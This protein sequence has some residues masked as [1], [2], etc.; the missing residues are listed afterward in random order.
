MGSFALIV[1]LLL[2]AAQAVF[3]LGLRDQ[4]AARMRT[5]IMLRAVPLAAFPQLAWAHSGGD[6]IPA[7]TDWPFAPDILVATLLVAGL[8][9]AGWLRR[10]D[11]AGAA[12]GWRHASFFAGLGALLAALQSPLDALA[13][14]SFTMHQLQH[15][16][17]RAFGP[18]LLL[19]AAP[20]TLLVAGMPQALRERVLAP[21]LASRTVRAAFGFFAHPAIAT[22]FLIAVPLFWHLPRYHNLSVLNLP[23]HYVMHVTMLL[24]GLFFF[25]RVLD[26]RPAPLGTGFAARIVMSSAAIA[27]NI[28]LGAYLTLKSAV[29]YPAYEANGRPWGLGALHDEQLGG[30]VIWI[31]G[32]MMFVVLL[33]IVIGLWGAREHRLEALRRRGIESPVPSLAAANRRLALRLAA[34]AV[35]VGAGVFGTVAMQRFLPKADIDQESP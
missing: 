23:V 33:L 25:W 9:V 4:K 14:Q 19:L 3:A 16:L 17:L 10:R 13:E 22:F 27:G 2:A 12:S 15:L 35:A 21:L 20:Q 29:L 6:A 30:L 32:S 31:P 18:M 28:P 7:R 8:Y 24:S 5:Q 26:P 1:A 11:R 34:I